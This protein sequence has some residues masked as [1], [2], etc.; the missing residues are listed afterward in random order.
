MNAATTTQV[1]QHLNIAEA[2]IVRLEE[3]AQPEICAVVGAAG[4]AYVLWQNAPKLWCT[5]GWCAPQ[6]APREFRQQGGFYKPAI[7]SFTLAQ[8]KQGCKDKEKRVKEA[9][10]EWDV[11]LHNVLRNNAPGTFNEKICVWRGRDHNLLTR[12]FR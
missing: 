11:Y 1:A 6:Q 2:A 8:T 7:E 10:P 3:W 5:A 9:K 12:Y 4:G